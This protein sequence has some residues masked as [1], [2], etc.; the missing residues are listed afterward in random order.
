MTL[1]DQC[2]IPLQQFLLCFLK[3]AL[4]ST[5]L[6][7]SFIWYDVT[8]IIDSFNFLTKWN[9]VL[10]MSSMHKT[11]EMKSFSSSGYLRMPQKC[12]FEE[13]NW[14]IPANDCGLLYMIVLLVSDNLVLFFRGEIK[15]R[16]S[17]CS[18]LSNQS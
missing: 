13:K 8:S 18:K 5:L 11:T 9:N 6:L 15:K 4:P 17:Y 7:L 1:C 2:W 10:E 14:E 3:V 12:H 16:K